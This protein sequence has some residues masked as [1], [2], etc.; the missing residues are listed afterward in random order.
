MQMDDEKCMPAKKGPGPTKG[1]LT[2]HFGGSSVE[3]ITKTAPVCTGQA[4]FWLT[5]ARVV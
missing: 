3:E 5:E 1:S 4:H 2:K